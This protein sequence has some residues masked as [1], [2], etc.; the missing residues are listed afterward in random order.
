MATIIDIAR[1]QDAH[2]SSAAV[3]RRKMAVDAVA[4]GSNNAALFVKPS[5]RWAKGKT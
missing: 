1:P 4:C 5:D 2:K 3:Q